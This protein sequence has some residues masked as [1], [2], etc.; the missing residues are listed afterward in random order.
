MQFLSLSEQLTRISQ[1][2]FKKLDHFWG[3]LAKENFFCPPENTFLPNF[4]SQYDSEWLEM[5]FKHNFRQCNI[6][7]LNCQFHTRI[8]DP[9]QIYREIKSASLKGSPSLEFYGD[10]RIRKQSPRSCDPCCVAEANEDV[11]LI[12]TVPIKSYL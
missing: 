2:L 8:S 7:H 3:N 12:I 4:F 1:C 11:T 5:D 10:N 6:F 9:K